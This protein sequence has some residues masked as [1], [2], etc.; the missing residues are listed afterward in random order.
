MTPEAGD[1]AGE[2]Y[3]KCVCRIAARFM[4]E[5]KQSRDRN[6]PLM[7]RTP[8]TCILISYRHRAETHN[9]V[10]SSYAI[11]EE[12][13]PGAAVSFRVPGN[14][15]SSVRIWLE[16]DSVAQRTKGRWQALWTLRHAS[17]EQMHQSTH[18]GI[19]CIPMYDIRSCIVLPDCQ[20]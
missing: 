8:V 3:E 19:S 1:D 10:V 16:A 5:T 18:I 11:I 2:A 13:R 15:R 17:T 12:S 9:T 4:A 14:T 20:C 7:T 6:E